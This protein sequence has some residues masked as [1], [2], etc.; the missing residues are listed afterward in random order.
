MSKTRTPFGGGELDTGP[1]QVSSSPSRAVLVD[2]DGST[3]PAGEGSPTA[4]E[5]KLS[6]RPLTRLGTIARAV[7]VLAT[8]AAVVF[9]VRRLDLHALATALRSAR[10]AWLVLAA[11]FGLLRLVSRAAIW[12]VSLHARPAVPFLRMIRYTV[13]AIAASVLTP[14][15]AGEALRL[16]LLRR[17]HGIPL[18][19]SIGI[20]LG[21]KILD[22]LALLVLVLPVPWLVPGL[23]A[24]VA[25]TIVGLAVLALPGLAIG[26]WAARR[27]LVPGRIARFLGQV[28]IL[29]EPRTLGWAFLACLGSWLLDVATLWAAMGA[30]GLFPGFGA[31]AFV[32]L[33]VNATLLVPSTPGN[34]GALEAGAV[35][36]LEVL[37]VER[38]RAV[39]TA[40]LY[41]AVQLVP[42]LIFALFNLRLVVGAGSKIKIGGTIEASSAPASRDPSGTTGHPPH[43]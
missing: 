4:T 29:R 38:H 24:W 18:A 22:G 14:A 8:L 31:V 34:V 33:V 9:I 12:Q 11:L 16:W 21:E 19:R 1:D 43:R 3:E 30:V 36:A 35:L 6:R 28:R 32:L 2:G 17:E 39:A 5:R 20:A 7:A 13:A 15:R 10:P 25:R 27:R 26:W 42:L 41:H 23:P 40:L 37:H